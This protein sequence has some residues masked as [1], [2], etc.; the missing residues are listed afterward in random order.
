MAQE[1]G[2]ETQLP[3]GYRWNDLVCKDGIEQLNFYRALLLQL[4]TSGSQRVQNIFVN[5]QTA[6]KQPR[7][8][9]K[10]VT[11]IDELDWYSAKEEGLGDLYEDLLERN[12]SEKK[13]G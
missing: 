4:G 11:S 9:K 8:L 6:L 2:T 7:I 13:S 1:T 10:L 3:E 5:S 12:A